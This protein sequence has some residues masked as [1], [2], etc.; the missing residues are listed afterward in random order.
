MLFE[1]L[2]FCSICCIV[3]AVAVSVL[4]LVSAKARLYE[5]PGETRLKVNRRLSIGACNRLACTLVFPKLLESNCSFGMGLPL[6][7]SFW[8]SYRVALVCSDLP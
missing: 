8:K 1:S 2:I 7:E 4:P 6:P 3:I 5:S